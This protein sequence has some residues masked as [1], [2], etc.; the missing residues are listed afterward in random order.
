MKKFAVSVVA[1]NYLKRDRIRHGV[2]LVLARDKEH[3]EGLA[4]EIAF[5]SWPQSSGWSNHSAIVYDVRQGCRTA[6]D[7]T[8]DV[9][10]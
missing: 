6:D 3:A 8:E 1:R 4:L 2:T 7:V 5:K 10:G 9:I